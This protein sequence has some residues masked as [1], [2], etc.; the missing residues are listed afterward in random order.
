MG[1]MSTVFDKILWKN[2]QK[3]LCLVFFAKALDKPLPFSYNNRASF[4]KTAETGE[5]PPYIIG[6]EKYSSW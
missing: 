1:G 6:M 3:N 4:Q 2:F 5:N